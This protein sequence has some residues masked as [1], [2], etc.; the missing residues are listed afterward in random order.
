MALFG[1]QLEKATLGDQKIK[2]AR[3]P[4]R[5]YWHVSK[6]DR[7]PQESV[8]AVGIRHGYSNYTGTV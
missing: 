2:P 5:L 3:L 7:A 1:S 8:S 6:T 4:D